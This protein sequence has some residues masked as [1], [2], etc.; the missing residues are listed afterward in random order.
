MTLDELLRQVRERQGSDL[1]LTAEA[2][3]LVRVDGATIAVTERPATADEVEALIRAA[4]SPADQAEFERTHE[5]NTARMIKGVGRFRLNV[6]RQRGQVGLVARIIPIRLPTADELGLPKALLGLVM[7]KRGLVLVTGATGAG[8]STTLAALVDHRNRNTRGHILTI[9]DPIEFV[10]E[11]QGCVITQREVGVDT[12]SFAAGLKSA[13]RQAPD[14]ILIGEMR[15]SETVEA[16][17]HFSETG[18]LVLGTLHA[19]NANQ[20]VERFL[21]FFPAEHQ[22]QLYA[23]LA[24]NL[25]GIVS[26]RLIP[27]TSGEGRVAAIE[28][29]LNTPRVADLIAKGEIGAL[30]TAI[31]DNA[32]DGSQS[33]DQ[34]LFEL[35][36]R[37]EITQDE[38]LR[39]ADSANNLRL[40]IKMSA[41]GAPATGAPQFAIRKEED[42]AA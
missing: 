14:V 42:E 30:K 11:H 4:L 35:L 7:Q 25:R 2:P 15:D 31:E 33:F 16:A 21:N 28:V 20:A 40:R 36:R 24:L 3:A 18:H 34:A 39:Q 38:A 32:L 27:R 22:A 41:G 1:Y 29:M 13:L 17:M 10:H 6:F 26:Q 9:E 23:Q 37:G 8:K 12:A 5:L 19:N